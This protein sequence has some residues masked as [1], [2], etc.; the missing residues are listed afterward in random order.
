MQDL[1]K[2]ANVPFTTLWKIRM[3]ETKN[4]GIDTVK[5]FAHLLPELTPTPKKAK[6]VKV[7]G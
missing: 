1:A 2:A 4:P 7:E 6:A 5:K 3:G